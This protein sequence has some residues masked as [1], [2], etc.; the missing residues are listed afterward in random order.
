MHTRIPSERFRQLLQS[1]LAAVFF[2]WT[3]WASAAAPQAMNQVP[4]YYRL[5][6]GTFEVGPGGQRFLAQ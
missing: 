4:G 1:L 6:V 5:M 3:G 2:A